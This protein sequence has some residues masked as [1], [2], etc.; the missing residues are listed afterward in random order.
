M[1]H[2]RVTVDK[3]DLIERLEMF[4]SEMK[5]G[6]TPVWQKAARILHEMEMS[7]AP[8]DTGLLRQSIETEAYSMGVKSTSS[9]ID[10]RNGFNYARIQHD[11]GYASGWAG[12]HTIVGKFYMTGPLNAVAPGMVVPMLDRE[13]AAIIRRCGLG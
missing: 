8:V 11:G 12:P 2:I 5:V 1:I 13:I 6:L 7:V 4:K 3:A 10:P 9:A